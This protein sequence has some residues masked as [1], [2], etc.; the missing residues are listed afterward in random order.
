MN[1]NEG[2]NPMIGLHGFYSNHYGKSQHLFVFNS[3]P[4][5]QNNSM[6]ASN[7]F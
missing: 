1:D 3:I 7:V 5:N 4:F 6:E 2:G